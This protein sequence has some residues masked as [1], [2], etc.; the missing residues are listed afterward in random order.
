MSA[1]D[2]SSQAEP[3]T[4]QSGVDIGQALRAVREHQG[5]SLENLAETTRVRASYLS[6]IEEL[7]LELLPS[8]PFTIGYI[9]AYASALGLD[10]EAAVERFRA[11]EPVLDEPLRAPL[12][13][14]DEHDPRVNSLIAGGCVIIVAIFLWNIARRAMIEDAPPP[15]AASEVITAKALA[16]AKPGPIVL[17]PPLPAPVESTTPPPYETPGLAQAVPTED[18]K[19]TLPG[20][21]KPLNQMT[22][23]PPLAQLPPKFVAKGMIYGAK[24]GEPSFVTVQALKS[25]Q[26]IVRGADGSLYF[27]RQ[28]AAGE[29]FRAPQVNGLTFNVTDPNSFQVFVGGQSRGVLPAAQASVSGL[30]GG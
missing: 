21:P 16:S 23:P 19:L 11:E 28:L 27:A 8:R 13:V 26:L 17:G 4:L 29:A 24:A 15:P 22:D 2:G 10:P 9:R 6:A 3:P 25:S 5:R 18:G 30:A 20:Q 1:S 7:R 12:G 14:Q